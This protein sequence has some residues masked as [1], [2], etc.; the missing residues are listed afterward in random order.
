MVDSDGVVE[1]ASERPDEPK[2]D[3][4]PDGREDGRHGNAGALIR[5]LLRVAVEGAVDGL[6]ID[7]R[8]ARDFEVGEE[9]DE[10]RADHAADTVLQ[11]RAGGRAVH[12]RALARRGPDPCCCARTHGN[13]AV[14]A[15]VDPRQAAHEARQE[16]DGERRVEADE[17]SG[18]RGD[19][20]RAGRDADEAN[21]GACR[22]ADGSG[23]AA[24]EL[25]REGRAG[26]VVASLLLWRP[27]RRH[28]PAA[29]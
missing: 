11:R 28:A 13:E 8:R 14:E 5:E 2:D 4:R 6:A 21:D 3:R 1:D 26:R 29:T 22:S 23:E 20:A 17:D 9:A 12:A 10:A 18:H 25:H 27:A 16:E 19:V 24:E 7:V 15:V